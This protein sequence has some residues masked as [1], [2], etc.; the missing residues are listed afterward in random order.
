MHVTVD[1]PVRAHHLGGHALE[2]QTDLSRGQACFFKLGRVAHLDPLNPLH[3]EHLPRGPP[4]KK[5]RHHDIRSVGEAG[6]QPSRIRGF[7]P[8]VQLFNNLLLDLCEE[9]PPIRHPQQ[10]VRGASQKRHHREIRVQR[11]LQSRVLDLHRNFGPVLQLRLVHLRQRRRS[12]GLHL[13]LLEHLPHLVAQFAL[14]RPT[15]PAETYRRHA[16]FQL[17]EHLPVLWWQRGQ[18]RCSLPSLDVDAPVLLTH[19]Q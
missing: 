8:E 7:V 5:P 9:P 16:I 1:K 13:K 12:R 11:A 4:R 10:E 14:E 2:Q 6:R 17:L 15:N 3:A 18:R 19:T